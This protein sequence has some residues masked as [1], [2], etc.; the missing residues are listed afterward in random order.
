ML[1]TPGIV[2]VEAVGVDGQLDSRLRAQIE[3]AFVVV[4]VALD[5]HKAIEVTHLELHARPPR[6]KMPAA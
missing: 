6:V 5:G 1:I 2:G 3:R 4:E